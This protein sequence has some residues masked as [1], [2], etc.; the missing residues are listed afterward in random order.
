MSSAPYDVVLVGSG[1]AGGMTAYVLTM[2]GVKVLMLE[3]GRDYDP[4]TETPMFNLNAD[5]PLRGS[6]TPDKPFGY[7]DATVDGGWRVPGEPYSTQDTEFLWWRTRMLGGR[8]NHWGRISLRMGEYDFKPRS[9][10]GLGVDWPMTYDDLAGYYDKTEALIGVYGSNEGLENTPGSS[11]GVLLPPPAPRAHELLTKKHCEPLGIPVIPAHL[12]ILSRRQAADRLS[13]F[14]FPGNARARRLTRDSMNSRSACFWATPCG[15]G[16]S[17]KANFQSPTVLLPPALASGNLTIRTNAMAREVHVNDA[18]QAA[19]VT[20]VDKLTGKDVFVAAR[21]VVVAASACESARL[22]L[23]SKSPL[24]PQGLAN[25]SGL[26]GKYVMDTV[27]AGVNGH[28]PALESLPVHNTDGSSGMHLYMPWWLYQEQ[29]AGSLNF[30]R[31][32]HIEFGGGRRMPGA[33]SFRGLER[34][35]GGSYGQAFKEDCRRYY[36][37]FLGFSGRGEMIPNEDSYCE[38][39]PSLKDQW[40]IPALRFHW[41]WSDDELNQV[42]HMQQT[43]AGIIESM[44]GRVITP[45]PDDPAEAI[46]KPGEIIH[47]VGGA[48]MGSDPRESVL[49]EFCQSWEVAN[50]YVTDGAGFVSNADKN[51]TLSIM[52]VAWRSADHLID[53]LARRDL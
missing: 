42:K 48:R 43:F 25:G 8:T 46:K 29:A 45:I 38:I 47:E 39:D 32:Y 5:A 51:P 9:R 3:A 13:K 14:L 17:I 52:A 23:N 6:G 7:Y 4:V 49:N 15:R 10:D 33:S 24:F 31:G 50:L 21:V 11:A 12:A 37:S 30:A 18:G 26:V 1:A 34:L 36:G 41:R 44:G 16:C 20:Y 22:L 53:A 2:A 40:G 19:G 28:I 35:T 27:G